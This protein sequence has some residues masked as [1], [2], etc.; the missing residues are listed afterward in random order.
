MSLEKNGNKMIKKY[1]TSYT[2][3]NTKLWYQN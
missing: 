2:N 3:K 1:E